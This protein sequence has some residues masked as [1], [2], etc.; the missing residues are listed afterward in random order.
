MVP[1]PLSVRHGLFNQSRAS[2]NYIFPSVIIFAGIPRI[3]NLSPSPARMV[4]QQNDLMIQIFAY[5]SLPI[6]STK[7]SF[8]KRTYLYLFWCRSRCFGNQ[9][10]IQW[11]EEATVR[12]EKFHIYLNDDEYSRVI[13]TLIRLKNSLISQGR[14]TDG[15]DDVLC[16]VLSTKKRK[17]K[18]KYIWT[19]KETAYT[20]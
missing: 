3:D 20:M 13:Q 5:D 12:E 4:K 11:M 1:F 15:V 8:Q 14:Y 7:S 9:S 19:R 17:L 16:K 10:K 18:I 6:T 2:L